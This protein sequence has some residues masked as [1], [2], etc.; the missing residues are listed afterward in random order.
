MIHKESKILTPHREYVA[1]TDFSQDSKDRQIWSMVDD[2][3]IQD[4]LIC[5][6][7][8]GL[9]EIFQV[10]VTKTKK[11]L[12]TRGQVFYTTMGPKTADKLM[13]DDAVFTLDENGPRYEQINSLAKLQ[14]KH[15]VYK[16]YANGIRP[17]FVNGVLTNDG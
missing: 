13:A 8:Y 2:M 14:R 17:Y 4:H 12:A 15:K 7:E 5:I 6:Q 16:V 10:R 3:L 9:E 11:V 1:V